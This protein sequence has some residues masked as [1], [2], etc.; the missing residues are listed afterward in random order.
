[1]A[2]A[3]AAHLVPYD[4]GDDLKPVIIVALVLLS[5]LG[6]TGVAGASNA[7]NHKAL[8]DEREASATVGGF[9]KP[10]AKDYHDGL[11][12]IREHGIKVGSKTISDV[13]ELGKLHHATFHRQ[14]ADQRATSPPSSGGEGWAAAVLLVIVGYALFAMNKTIRPQ[15]SRNN[16]TRG[17]SEVEH[18]KTCAIVPIPAPGLLPH[19]DETFYLS[20]ANNVET[21]AEHHH[22]EFVG[23]YAGISVPIMRRFSIRTGTSRG[24]KVDRITV[25]VDDSGTLYF[26]NQRVVFIGN[27]KT[28]DIPFSRL[29]AVEPYVDGLKINRSNASPLVLRTGSQSEAVILQRIMANDLD[30]LRTRAEVFAEAEKLAPLGDQALAE[31]QKLHASGKI[32]DHQLHETEEKVERLKVIRE[33]LRGDVAHVAPPE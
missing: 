26:S 3:T 8:N 28:I 11:V 27:L 13:V 23:G 19:K 29:V 21:I 33:A 6:I 5:L 18:A 4:S 7:W 1:M 12:Y 20:T 10:G 25:D 32:T 16:Q 24:R 2:F 17:Q 30:P 14:V 15:A 31:A 22:S 9:S